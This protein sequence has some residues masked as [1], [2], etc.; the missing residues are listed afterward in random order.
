MRVLSIQQPFAQLVVRGVKR[1]EVRTWDTDYRGRIAIHASSAVPS[2]EVERQWQRN[3][4]MALCFADQGWLDREDLKKLPRSA[5]VGTVELVGVH[6][7]KEVHGGKTDLFTWNWL[8]Q[9]LELATR[10]PQTGELRPIQARLRPLPVAI[11]SDQYAWAFLRPVEIE[12]IEEVTGKQNL[13]TLPDDVS[14]KTSER[15]ARSLAGQWHPPPVD[16]SRR[17]ASLE[18][19]RERFLSELER[20]VRSVEEVAMR[21]REI[22]RLEFENPR[23]EE[24]FHRTLRAYDKE[25]LIE[26]PGGG[27]CYVRLEEPLKKLFDGRDVVP[28]DEF[29]LALRR[30]VTSEVKREKEAVR[31]RERRR[32]LLKF[33]ENLM[34]TTEESPSKAASIRDLLRRELDR[35]LDEEE[36]EDAD[37]AE[38]WQQEREEAIPEE[39]LANMEAEFGRVWNEGEEAVLEDA[40]DA[41]DDGEDE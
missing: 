8:T 19:W 25:H 11:A 22:N 5:I 39:R 18:A 33:L 6:L 41:A 27:E 35:M 13:W 36:W 40:E 37:L 16:A 9:L 38:L 10:D 15:E 12:P 7:G 20:E 21:R 29:E 4:A 17:K 28:Y 14:L 31:E 30:F 24:M 34:D 2:Q 32:R 3:R 26:T 23:I 1:L